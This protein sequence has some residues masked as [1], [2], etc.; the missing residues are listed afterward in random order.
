MKVIL[1][2]R[3]EIQSVSLLT[4]GVPVKSESWGERAP[5]APPVESACVCSQI[6]FHMTSL[7][8]SVADCRSHF[9]FSS[10]LLI[11]F[12]F[13]PYYTFINLIPPESAVAT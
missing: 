12:F 4:R 10:L 13:P 11:D 7:S 1:G 2:E 8:P 9:A 3:R 6:Y 5:L